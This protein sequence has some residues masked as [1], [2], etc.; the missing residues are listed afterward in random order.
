VTYDDGYPVAD[1]SY[2][3][4]LTNLARSTSNAAYGAPRAAHG[5]A[6]AARASHVRRCR[7][8]LAPEN[9]PASH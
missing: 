4:P 6:I 3:F 8:H 2:G 9:S 5:R 7:D 1:G